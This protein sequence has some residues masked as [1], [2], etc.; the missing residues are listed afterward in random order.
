MD[1]IFN[2]IAHQIL[3]IWCSEKIL[4][5]YLESSDNNLRR[6]AFAFLCHMTFKANVMKL[7]AHGFL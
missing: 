4:E 1:S 3:S 5:L 6:N 2:G 7:L